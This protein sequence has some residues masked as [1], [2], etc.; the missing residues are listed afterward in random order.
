MHLLL[1]RPAWDGSDVLAHDLEVGPPQRMSEREAAPLSTWSGGGDHVDAALQTAAMGRPLTAAERSQRLEAAAA[2]AVKRTASA[3]PEAE[4]KRRR[5]EQRQGM[6]L[7]A[8][9]E[10]HSSLPAPTQPQ[11]PQLQPTLMPQTLL[12]SEQLLLAPLFPRGS[13]PFTPER[14]RA[15]LR[16]RWR[17]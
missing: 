15:L 6:R 14:M 8:R 10:R 9:L 1:F 17:S 4:S 3:V 2:A 5:A 13:P 7:A 16:F 11:L 12:H